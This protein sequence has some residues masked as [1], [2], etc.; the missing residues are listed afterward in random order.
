MK[1]GCHAVLFAGA[2]ADD[3]VNVLTSLHDAG[4]EGVEI[5]SRFFG[6]DKSEFLCEA[7]EKAQVQLCGFHGGAM[8]QDLLDD[9]E[10]ARQEQIPTAEFLQHVPC[11]DIIFTGKPGSYDNKNM[12]D[13]RLMTPEA[14]KTVAE[15]LN[16]ISAW[17]KKT[18]GVQIHYH[19][20]HWEFK[21]NGNIFNALVKY[22]PD[23]CFALD[24]G[25]AAV[26]GYDPVKLICEDC[27]G[28]IRYLHLRDM[29]AEETAKYTEYD[30]IKESFTELGEGNMDY[31]GLLGAVNSSAVESCWVVVE[32]EKGAVDAKRYGK[33]VDFLRKTLAEL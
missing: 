19:N 31:K 26:E 15:N 11:K 32:Y 21:N 12:G 28:R 23:V 10:K 9:P 13:D 5:G 7:L 30:D 6:R 14:A 18:Y 33:A 2:I 4:A 24:V 25:W 27:R 29:I 22:A 20:H 3:T 17:L 8:L 16:N 1:I